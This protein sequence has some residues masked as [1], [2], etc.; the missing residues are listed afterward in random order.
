MAPWSDRGGGQRPAAPPSPRPQHQPSPRHPPPPPAGR[1]RSTSRVTEI[2][3]W[4]TMQNHHLQGDSSSSDG[5]LHPRSQPSRSRPR[6][7]RSVSHPFPSLFSSK[8]RPSPGSPSD[9]R[10]D[11]AGADES[12][13]SDSSDD[14]FGSAPRGRPSPAP[15]ARGHRNGSSVAGSRDFATGRCMTCA[16][17]VRWPRELHMFR[18]T[19]CMTIN[20]LRPLG[21]EGWRD[22]AQRE[23][24]AGA[25]EQTRP[26][27][28]PISLAHTKS[29][30]EQCLRSYLTSTLK[31]R[32]GQAA[33][34]LEPPF[35]SSPN[36]PS[37]DYLRVPSQQP[38]SPRLALQ[39]KT[40]LNFEPRLLTGPPPRSPAHPHRRAPSWA[41]S[42]SS[43]YSMSLQEKRLP[44]RDLRDGAVPQG[45]GGGHMHPP[46][47]P[48]PGD[49]AKRIFRPLEDYVVGC[50]TSFHCL[51]SSFLVPRSHPPS[52]HQPQQQQQQQQHQQQH[53][54]S[55]RPRRPSEHVELRREVRSTSYPVPDLDPKLLLL[56]DVAE[57]GTWWIGHEESIPTRT[58]SSRSQSGHHQSPVSLR[59]PYIDW[60]DLEEWYTTTTQAARTWPDIYAALI[61]ADPSLAVPPAALQQIESLFLAAQEHTQHALLKAS[62]T[63]LKR[64]GR[65]PSDPAD[66]RFLLLLAANPLL[67]A[68]FRPFPGKF[69]PPPGG[70]S[71]RGGGG[72]GSPTTGRHSAILKRIIGLLSNAPGECHAHLA[73][74]LA[75][76]PVQSFIQT[77]ELIFGFLAYRLNRQSEKRHDAAARVDLMGGLIPDVGPGESAASLHAALGRGPN[78][79]GNGKKGA[80]KKKRVVYQ[81]DWQIKAAAT[82]L[83]VVFKGNNMGGG[84]PGV[85]GGR[86]SGGVVKAPG[87]ILATSE[88]YVTL[89]DEADLVKEFEAFSFCQHPY[90]LSMGAKIQILERDARKRMG[91]SARDAFF[92]SIMSNR[93]VQQFLVLNIRRECLVD[94]SLK[95]VS[96][97][98]GGGG[99]E[100]KKGLKINFRGEEGVDAGGLRKEWFLLLVRELFNPDHGMFLYDE[101]SHYCY[102]NPHSLEPSEQFFLV[103][104]VLGLAIYNSTI[105]DVALPPF[106]FRK[107]LL[108]GHN[109]PSPS[110]PPASTPPPPSMTYTLSDLAEYRPALARGLRALLDYEGD[111]V[112]SVFC[113]DFCV[114]IPRYGAVE[115]VPLCPH[116]ERRAVTN[117]NRREYVDAYVR[118]MLDGAVARQ[119]EPFKRGFFTVCVGGTGTEGV[120]GLFRPEEI[121]LLIRGAGGVGGGEVDVEGLGGGAVYEGWSSRDKSEKPSARAGRGK[122][123]A[124]EEEDPTIAW[125]WEAFASA[126][127]GRQRALLA[128]ITGS[129]RVPAVGA[130]ALGIRVMCLGK[131]CGRFPTARTCFN[132]IGL[133]SGAERAVFEERLWRAVEESEGFGLK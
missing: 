114:A 127:P 51:N 32:T 23:G 74:W 53:T 73:A 131:E 95:A 61:A 17:L 81:E 7:T 89:L 29:L 9:R 107:L 25:E 110:S 85:V 49:D 129:D 13:F 113:L 130:A 76:Y 125:F 109:H 84:K 62:E 21:R 34:C 44:L 57:N 69:Q 82:V 31:R 64:P 12:G 72:G 120:L 20:D 33:T 80:E 4:D 75:R 14:G 46:P 5:D 48:S 128:F 15:A 100:V 2:D 115:R 121:E 93:V 65:R 35:S 66:L 56:G 132:L 1:Y 37:P 63:L 86:D 3:V 70:L 27:D 47:P 105:L 118:Y 10:A 103:G 133:W 28:K 98:I 102:F 71:P 111:D 45:L 92:D 18:C 41:G 119:F 108:S 22:D 96:E 78:G 117:A 88:F 106:A 90:L 124:E 97:V 123:Q 16:S 59:S 83:G 101:D 67:H 19:I 43:S 38:G 58:P 24:V 52:G 77:K 26:S 50:V 42:T 40:S 36:L 8:K 112:E 126:P 116:G 6:H 122:E 87:Q 68:G 30:V 39:P 79:G 94:D 11:G 91:T 104:V 60:P 55:S 54:L 99:E